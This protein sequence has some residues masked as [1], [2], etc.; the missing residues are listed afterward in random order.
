METIGRINKDGTV[1]KE[2]C[3]L[4]GNFGTIYK[5]WDAFAKKN[6]DTCYVSEF[7]SCEYSYL[8]YVDIA[9]GLFEQYGYTGDP[10]VL[11]KLLFEFSTWQ[12]PS[13]LIEEWDDMGE[14]AEYPESHGITGKK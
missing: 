10:T 7:S 9:K 4:N 12:S 6:D 5:N 3:E 8:G 2:Y 14:F 13:T 11:A 1:E